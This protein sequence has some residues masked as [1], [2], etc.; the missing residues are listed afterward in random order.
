VPTFWKQ[1]FLYYFYHREYLQREGE[2]YPYT[3]AHVNEHGQKLSR[4]QVLIQH[5][6]HEGPEREVSHD[7]ER[8][9]DECEHK[10]GPVKEPGEQVPVPDHARL[11]GDHLDNEISSFTPHQH[12]I[13]YGLLTGKQ[14]WWHVT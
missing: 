1:V 10:D 8:G 14:N 7:A 4:R 13:Q 11:Y 9:E 6:L 3:D 2:Y 5:L 12:G